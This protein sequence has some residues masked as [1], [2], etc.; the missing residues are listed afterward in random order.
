MCVCDGER[1]RERVCVCDGEREK[2][3]GG[4]VTSKL[5]FVCTVG[6]EWVSLLI[7]VSCV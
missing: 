1:E 6:G 4:D 3:G 7:W 2:G 5:T